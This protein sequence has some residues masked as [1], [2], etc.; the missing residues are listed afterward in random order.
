MKLPNIRRKKHHKSTLSEEPQAWLVGQVLKGGSM[1]KALS[2]VTMVI[3]LGAVFLGL[4]LSQTDLLNFHTRAAEV[5][6]MD[7]ETAFNQQVWQ[8]ELERIKKENNIKVEALRARLTKEADLHEFTVLFGLA[9]V[10]VA[11][12]VPSVALAYYLVRRGNAV[13]ASQPVVT[14]KPSPR[15]LEFPSTRSG[16][17]P[18]PDKRKRKRAQV[19][20]Y[21]WPDEAA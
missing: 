4:S 1:I 6:Q 3:L 7:A 11:T 10:A 2:F 13:R 16:H 19:A 21:G 14:E 20:S 18:A 17:G 5:R 9:V 8:A 12:L 15:L